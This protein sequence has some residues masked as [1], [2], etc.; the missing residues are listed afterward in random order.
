MS[1]AENVTPTS[2]HAGIGNNDSTIKKSMT[3]ISNACGGVGD[4]GST[5][6]QYGRAGDNGSTLKRQ[7]P[8]TETSCLNT[9]TTTSCKKGR[10]DADD[11]SLRGKQLLAL[12]EKVLVMSVDS[13]TCHHMRDCFP[14]L[15]KV[16]GTELDGFCVDI[17]HHIRKCV[18]VRKFLFVLLN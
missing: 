5:V 14:E 3:P 11:T 1:D 2:N 16:K 6:K 8:L 15:S 17:L 9:S 4:N 12:L 18:G 7:K 13:F 10:F